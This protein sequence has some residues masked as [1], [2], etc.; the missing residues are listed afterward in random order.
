MAYIIYTSGS[1]GKP[2]GTMIKQR[3]LVNYI[4]WADKV[5]VKNESLD[6]PL[7]SS[8]SFDLTVTSI[9]TPLISGNKIVV[10][11][12]QE[13]EPIIRQVFKEN[14]VGIVKLTPAHL[15]MI[16]EID[17]SNSSIKRLI[18][19]GEDL[20]AELAKEVYESF[21]KNVEIYNEY[22]PTETVVGCML[23]KYDY[24]KDKSISVPIGKPADNVQIYILDKEK[25][26]LPTGIA[27][28]IYVGGDGVSKGYINRE[29]LTAEKFIANPF[30]PGEQMYR[31]GDLARWMPDGNIEFLG[32]I[33]NQV[34]IRGFRIELG[35][36]EAR[37]LSYEGIE[38][39]I[40][41]AREDKDSSYL[42]AYVSGT[43][44][45]KISE[46]RAYLNEELPEYMIPSY[47]L[48]LEK[49][50]ITANGKVDRK[51]LPEPDGSIVTGIEYVAPTNETEEK[52]TAIWQEVLGLEKVGINDNFFELG[53]HSLK[54]I[55]ISAKINMELNVSVPL[56]EIF[57]TPTI[58]GL[59][60]YVK[61]TKQSIYSRIEPAE[62]N[63]YYPLSSA[64]KR[65]YA[66]Q[67]FEEN[68]TSYNIP[69][70]MTIVGV[71]DKS[72]LE[73]AFDKLIQRHEALRTSF[74]I[75]N[76]E[77]VQVVHKEVSFKIEYAEA[78]KEKAE[79]I[80]TVFVKA[81]DLRKAPLLRVAL[82]KINDTE[83][84]L[85]IDKHH[86][87][88]DGVS[89]GILTNEF[90]ELY[91]GKEL[92]KLRIQYK[93]FAVWQN[94][95]FKS[96]EIKKQEEYWLNVFNDE[97]P[98]LS[99]PTD[100][101]RPNIQNF[102]GDSIGF[103]L[104]EELTDKLKQIA[105]ET[106]STMYMVLLSACNILLS[107]YS[108][109]EDII[110][111]SPIAGR[112]HAD[113]QNIMGMFVNMLAM[114]NYPESD[115]TLKEFLIEVKTTSLQAFENQDYQFEELIDKLNIK[116]DLSRNPLFDVMFS[117]Q[118]ID[119]EELQI[120]GLRFKPY[121]IDSKIAK[122]DMTITAI[123]ANKTIVI[124][125]NYCTK[126][127]N[128]QTIENMSKH[129]ISILNS[130][131]KNTSIR[132]SEL[133]ML[134]EEEI[135]KVLV[136]FN[137]T[138]AE[139]PKDKTLYQ[140]FEEQASKTPDNIAAI[141][142]EKSITY[143]ELDE[144]S[145]QLARVLM[146]NGVAAESIVAIS[147]YRSL[148]MTIGIMAIQK[149]G[150]AYLPI[151]PKYPEDRIRYILEDSN[152]NVLLTQSHLQGNYKFEDITV[153]AIDNKELYRGD[154]SSLQPKVDQ[155]I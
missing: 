75:I 100:Y 40:V 86:I 87:I 17:N 123:E 108:G 35:E 52:L 109:Q 119:T 84:I 139:Y 6:F 78:D 107:R 24:D 11:K 30:I 26:L 51:S 23:Y 31:T 25:Q 36:I 62:E 85:M 44:E 99:I 68:S 18:L 152:A 106:G 121:E 13:D 19:G 95:M 130:I 57:K 79:E 63:E 77:P 58:K 153:I 69:M 70:V 61:G 89:M 3:G 90:I 20:K 116:R 88:S 131:A 140:L 117:M 124:D 59:A 65:M 110:I 145:N 46:L 10:Y 42:C 49:L 34:K 82:T 55:N 76:G 111:G 101:Q 27:G 2:K 122:L 14:K 54:A 112:P 22:G 133:E 147:L 37:L 64:Q 29:E 45:F 53:G 155:T 137:N 39:V 98:V 113:L 103:E 73:K 136:E 132:L 43:R 28:E 96:G 15:S 134:S 21:N 150:G 127:F 129:L 32:R 146:E 41:I 93:D 141:F 92:P 126:L 104:N 1:T 143:K 128:K 67:Q 125:L 16:K 12:D 138:K 114:R 91:D 8:F 56:R 120:E 71:F 50:P 97:A 7:Y 81:F 60:D 148:E 115:K 144:K 4:T 154:S 48:Q 66:L 83:H 135:H 118:N 80:A 105:R 74:E 9:F 102:E 94:E 38:E 149:A 142:E 72:K 5:Y 47:F 33:D 151:D